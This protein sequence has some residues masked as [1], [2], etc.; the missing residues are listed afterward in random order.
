MGCGL[1]MKLEE[2]F[3]LLESLLRIFFFFLLLAQKK[4]IHTHEF[5]SIHSFL[6]SPL[7]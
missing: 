7:F 4:Y 6:P 1:G 5:E 2:T 3:A